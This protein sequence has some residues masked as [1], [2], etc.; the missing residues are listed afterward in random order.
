VS[1]S[2]VTL[3]DLSGSW[4]ETQPSHHFL[5]E[6]PTS[7]APTFIMA[8]P[9]AHPHPPPGAVPPGMR[10]GMMPPPPTQL[11]PQTAALM[12]SLPFNP[13]SYTYKDAPPR[14]PGAPPALPIL[15]CKEHEENVCTRCGTDFTDINQLDLVMSLISPGMVPPPPNIQFPNTAESIKG[16]RDKGNVSLSDC[17][18]CIPD[19]SSSLQEQFKLQ[20]YP[21]AAQLYTQSMVMSLN[22]PAWEQGSFVKDEISSA[23]LNRSVAASKMGAWYVLERSTCDLC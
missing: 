2:S 13:V 23:L 21:Q 7:F 10:P 4:N 5:H 9:H 1:T 16:V 6:A 18:R 11:P 22:R 12:D 20:Q 3:R 8:Q 15:V 14:P 19:H 17:A